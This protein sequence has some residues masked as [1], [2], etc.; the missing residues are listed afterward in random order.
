MIE[1]KKGYQFIAET[2]E[3]YGVTHVFYVEAML[4]LTLREL[5]HMRVKGIMTH[6][7]GAAGYMADGYARVTGRPGVCMA[8][9]IGAANMT[10]GVQ[11]AW[12]ANSPVIAITGKKRAPYQYRNSYQEADHR[13][14][15]ESITK[16]NADVTQPEQLPYLLRQCFREAVSGKPRPVHLD[17]PNRMG[18]TTELASIYEPVYIDQAFKKYPA[19]R[20]AAEADQVEEAARIIN[21]A[22]RPVIVA[23]RGARIS[24][25]GD[26]IYELALKGDI[27]VVTS[28]DGKTLIDETDSLWAGIVGSYGMDCA[29]RTVSNADL[30]IFIGTQTGDQTTVDWKVPLPD[31]KAVQ[32]DIEAS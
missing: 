17:I 29:N 5:D 10:G 25:A 12:L 16:F 6:T 32:I 8:Q 14:F 7:E 27:P 20:P 1:S 4:R 11:D 3:G 24:D 21:E 15:Y 22:E 26:E 19:F 2:L 30:V 18:R 13:L 31:V 23:G 28:P 9:S